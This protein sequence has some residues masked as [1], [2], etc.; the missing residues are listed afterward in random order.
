MSNSVYIQINGQ[1]LVQLINTLDLLK[2][3]QVNFSIIEE[4]AP[5]KVQKKDLKLK[6]TLGN[7]GHDVLE[8]LSNGLTYNEIAE[9]EDISVDGVRYYIKK[10]FKALN[11]NNGRDAIRIYLTELR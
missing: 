6:R 5:S 2:Q 1:S 9:Q 7:K 3:N 4:Q 10:I 8:A 11:V